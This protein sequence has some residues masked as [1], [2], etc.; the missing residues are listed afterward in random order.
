MNSGKI[1]VDPDKL[2]AGFLNDYIFDPGGEPKM[3]V[4]RYT[5]RH[6]QGQ[7]CHW[8][9]GRYKRVSDSDMKLKVVKFLHT[10]NNYPDAELMKISTNL[11]SNILLCLAA[12]DGVYM[13]SDR[14][15]GTWPDAREELGILT[16]VF[17]NAMVM[18]QNGKPT[19]IPLN[20]DYFNMVRLPFSYDPAATYE[21]WTKYLGEIFQLKQ[22]AKNQEG[23]D[24][25]SGEFEETYDYVPDELSASILS[26]YTGLCL[27]SDTS[28][29]KILGLIGPKR[30]G[31]GTYG[32]ILRLLVGPENVAAPTLADL[33]T[34]FGLQGLLDKTVAVIG[35]ANIGGKA[36]D[37][38]RAVERLKSISGEDAQS[39]NRKGMEFRDVD[40][41]DVRFVI[42]ANELQNL[43]DPTG[44]LSS[45]FIYL[46]LTQS[47]EG[48]ENTHLFKDLRRE[49][50]GIFNWAIA[51]LNNLYKRGYFLESQAGR[52]TRRDAEKLGSSVISFVEDCCILKNNESAHCQNVYNAYKIW[53]EEEGR[54][55]LGR[56]RFYEELTRAFPIIIRRKCRPNY[57]TND[58][59]THLNYGTNDE[60]PVWTFEGID[61]NQEWKARIYEK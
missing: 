6:W 57:G 3:G 31:K 18:L 39:V 2:A 28:F 59:N 27:T 35:D 21:G 17:D 14:K 13:D 8:Y 53:I 4:A 43:Q 25:D 19:E 45:R 52:T 34:D 38:L 55:K 32:R 29:Q 16:F 40:K 41:L 47:F 22:L 60:N 15:V 50:P 10:L 36:G 7:F 11:T 24:G 12:T 1:I 54:G 56:T 5:L 44:A 42:M 51:G 48:R 33:T 9:K 37:V 30:S 26:E 49:L 20:P 46:I 58:Q 23:F 61:L